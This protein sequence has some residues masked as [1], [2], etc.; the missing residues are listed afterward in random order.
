M[1]G[2]VAAPV[3]EDVSAAEASKARG[4]DGGTRPHPLR[5]EG[6]PKGAVSDWRDL[7]VY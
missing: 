1:G 3:A 6:A 7:K 2:E 5:P 4:G